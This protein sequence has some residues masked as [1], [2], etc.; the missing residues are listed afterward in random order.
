MASAFLE[1]G[2]I[3]LAETVLMKAVEGDKFYDN[4]GIYSRLVEALLLN[5]EKEKALSLAEIYPYGKQ[6]SYAILCKNFAEQ[7]EYS[8]VENCLGNLNANQKIGILMS[9]IDLEI[10]R[11][12]KET[13]EKYIKLA[14]EAAPLMEFEDE[15]KRNY[16]IGWTKRHIEDK[17]ERLKNGEKKKEQPEMTLAEKATEAAK[18]GDLEAAIEYD[19]KAWSDFYHK[20]LSYSRQYGSSDV[21]FE[22]DAIAE[23]KFEIGSLYHKR[24]D[25]INAKKYLSEACSWAGR[26]PVPMIRKIID[27]GYKDVA[28]KTL[29]TAY[30]EVFKA[31]DENKAY[32][33]ELYSGRNAEEARK[34][35]RIQCGIGDFAGALKTQDHWKNEEVLWDILEGQAKRSREQLRECDEK[36]IGEVDKKKVL[37]YAIKT[38]D[39]NLIE[40]LGTVMSEGEREETSRDLAVSSDDLAL[41]TYGR[42]LSGRLDYEKEYE[43]LLVQTKGMISE[44]VERGEKED[45]SILKK[46]LIALNDLATEDVAELV[47]N[48]IAKA[49][50]DNPHVVRL[51]KHLLD[52]EHDDSEKIATA[53]LYQENL[54]EKY[55]SYIAEK[56]VGEKIKR[57]K[58]GSQ[59]IRDIEKSVSETLEETDPVLHNFIAKRLFAP[60]D[61]YSVGI[62]HQIVAA[63]I[64]HFKGLDSSVAK[65]LDGF[66]YGVYDVFYVVD[67]ISSFK[68]LDNS[69]ALNA[70]SKGRAEQVIEYAENFLPFD[71]K[72]FHDFFDEQVKN[73][74][75]SAV[76]GLG[77][78]DVCKE[79]YSETLSRYQQWASDVSLPFP[80]RKVA[81]NFLAGLAKE[82]VAHIE[83]EFIGIIKERSKQKEISESKWALD[84]TQ[85][86]AFYTLMKLDN[87]NVSHALFDLLPEE[88]VHETVK[89]AIMKKMVA[90][91]C[92]FFGNG[93]RIN[94]DWWYRSRKTHEIDWKDLRFPKAIQNSIPSA[95]LRE[96]SEDCL[97]P[98]SENSRGGAGMNELWEK[99][100]NN[101]PENAFL[102]LYKFTNGDDVLLGKFQNMYASIRKEGT[103]K[104]NLLYG[105]IHG[106]WVD[107]KVR[108]RLT[109]NLKGLDLASKE[110]ADSLSELLRHV[111]FLDRIQK[112]KAHDTGDNEEDKTRKYEER[113]RLS[114]EFL[115]LFLKEVGDLNSLNSLIK[116]ATTKKIQEILPNEEITAEKI[117]AIEKQWGDLEPIFT[118]LGRYPALRDYIAEMAAHFDNRESWK[119]WRYDLSDYDV[120]NQIG[121]LSD[122][123]TDVWKS[124][125]FLE[126]GDIML[127][128]EG[129]D[130]P[131]QIQSIL[132]DATLVHKHIF[133]PE[134]GQDKHEFI[135]NTVAGIFGRL[136]ED[137]GN[138]QDILEK[139]LDA[140]LSEAGNIDAVIDFNNIPRIRKDIES[141]FGAGKE[142][143][144]SSKT[145]N[146]VNFL[147]GYLSS[148]LAKALEENYAALERGGK[149]A[150][151][152]ELFPVEMKNAAERKISE[153]EEKYREALA[154]DTWEKL[155]IDKNDLDNL[156]PL[157]QKRQELKSAAD[158]VRLL[159]LSNKLIA[160]NRISEN[161]GKKS[162]ES[163]T[164]VIERLKKY[165]KDSPLLQDIVNV[166]FVLNEKIDFGEKRR[167]AMIFTDDP[168]VLWQAGKYP[169][170]SGSCQHYAEGSYAEQLMGYVSDANC[171][172][173]YLIDLNKLP[174]DVKNEIKE[175]G[176]EEVKENIP[177]QRLLEASLARSI[178][179]MTK[180]NKEEPVILLEPTYSSVNKGDLG[181]D[182]YFNLFVDLLVA[183]PMKAKMAR[184]GGNERV[185]KGESRSPEDQYEDIDLYSV[186]FIQKDSEHTKEE[187]EMIERIRSSPWG[188]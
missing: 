66:E 133:N 43:S 55:F 173:S 63:N 188:N 162:G 44:Y 62:G 45:R 120:K 27:L 72:T 109:E 64:T 154:S 97:Y 2:E 99:K 89:H 132:R 40:S 143:I 84:P 46:L 49:D 105:I 115:E 104:D 31:I 88:N 70:I 36:G 25:V 108:Q 54:P 5:G 141:T 180:N 107:L 81:I 138:E 106:S 32:I 1:Q 111:V 161:S 19:E 51:L 41:M 74:N 53:V 87:S 57:W 134:M 92:D 171:K 42:S 35:M 73:E 61:N 174:D 153:M 128:S 137:R 183:E 100:Y 76:A 16:G 185:L 181:M 15:L 47:S 166:E 98:L 58:N 52:S 114:Q 131:K 186:K 37:D 48:E 123:E 136:P 7:G 68:E 67:Y 129:S 93:A 139:E 18:N 169:L 147:S 175:K 10:K 13:A 20:S 11:N 179:K 94:L 17:K 172:V 157:Y 12:N 69:V 75:W 176:F 113:S 145:K 165:F 159:G 95:E 60:Q 59:S 23:T 135:H 168:Q 130:K 90:P 158:L 33:A 178:V 83:E 6:A 50:V 140:V 151:A 101:I 110:D 119:N 112:M 142:I 38:E 22:N 156:S 152:D 8:E 117:E 82:G 39:K 187:A 71:Q 177:R 26:T 9:L 150:V 184:G 103:K 121:H 127:A 118:Y 28:Y 146:T 148:D 79:K 21:T 65:E 167:L 116:E 164:S 155:R 160:T 4:T 91:D 85:E 125:H 78:I 122:V 29:R 96:L 56:L 144:P 80:E 3:S 14:E 34:L 124:D 30:H 24:G 102:Q 182:K 126:V 170:G 77:K 86:A 163:I 149:G